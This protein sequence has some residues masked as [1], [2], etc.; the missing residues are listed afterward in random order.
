M[1]NG[2]NLVVAWLLAAIAAGCSSTPIWDARFGDPVRVIAAQQIIDPDA[3][4]N[5]DPVKGI[6]G[7]AAQG[8]MGEY[9]KS[10]VQ[11]EPQTTSFSIGVGGQ[12]GK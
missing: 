6:D 4:R 9:Q 5:A 10:F 3:S 11:P 8:S 1:N 12:S 7:K 2:I